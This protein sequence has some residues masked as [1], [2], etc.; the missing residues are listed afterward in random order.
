MRA[1]D[2]AGRKRCVVKRDPCQNSGKT[3]MPDSAPNV[4]QVEFT[5]EFK[6]NIRQLA[7]KYQHLLDDIQPVI[8][9]LEAGQIRG[10]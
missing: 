1:F 4:V 6:C 3:S 8:N 9:Q 7:K 2:T 10:I 5:P